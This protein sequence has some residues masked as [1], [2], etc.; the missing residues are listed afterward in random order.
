[1]VRSSNDPDK[2]YPELTA[3]EVQ[4][5]AVEVNWNKRMLLESR[6]QTV[7]LTEIRDLLQGNDGK[8]EQIREHFENWV[9]Q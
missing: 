4:D 1:M 8:L 7:V 5:C 6:R 9:V 2:K 3:G